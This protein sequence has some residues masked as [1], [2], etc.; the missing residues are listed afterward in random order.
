[1]SAT[2][3]TSPKFVLLDRA[4]LICASVVRACRTRLARIRV[5]QR[6]SST[7]LQDSPAAEVILQHLTRVRLPDG[8]VEIRGTALAEFRPGDRQTTVYVAFCPPF[9]TLPA[10]QANIFD[11]IEAELKVVQLLHNG[12]QFE[13]RLCEPADEP[14]A[15]A[16]EFVVR[17][18]EEQRV[19]SVTLAV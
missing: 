6:L 14:V 15:L 19:P 1:V 5:R 18:S 16:I 2:D 12:V 8:R 10:I 4:G 17:E 11:D 3:G 7:K 9:E 13:L